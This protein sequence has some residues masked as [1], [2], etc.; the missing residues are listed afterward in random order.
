MKKSIL[1]IVIFTISVSLYAQKSVVKFGLN[2]YQNVELA[3]ENVVNDGSSIEVSFIYFSQIISS[4]TYGY[5]HN[6]PPTS[7]GL[8]ARGKYKIYF[9]KVAPDGWYVAPAIGYR[10]TKVTSLGVDYGINLL[11]ID[12]LGGYQWVFGNGG[13]FTLDINIG[14][15]YT[16]AMGE[17]QNR[18][19]RSFYLPGSLS[20]GFAF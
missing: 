2:G 5:Y 19:G 3:Y 1:I 11:S 20:L 8:G 17:N 6:S 15:G 4:S 14:L 13:G 18:Y 12:G 16:N 10:A 7:T 9:A